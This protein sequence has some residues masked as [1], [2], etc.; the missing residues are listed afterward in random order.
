MVDGV[1]VVDGFDDVSRDVDRTEGSEYE[2]TGEGRES[3]KGSGE[4]GKAARTNSGEGREGG[5]GKQWR[6]KGRRQGHSE[7]HRS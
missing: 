5:K 4:E 7:P 2:R 1:E 6:G 3:G